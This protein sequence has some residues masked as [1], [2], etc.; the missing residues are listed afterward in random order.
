[1][2]LR[3]MQ[4]NVIKK[5]ESKRDKWHFHLKR[6]PALVTVAS[7]FQSNRREYEYRLFNNRCRELGYCSINSKVFRPA[8]N[9]GGSNEP[10]NL[11]NNANSYCNICLLSL[12]FTH[13][14]CAAQEQTKPSPKVV[15]Y[16]SKEER[17]CH[18]AS[19][20]YRLNN[21]GN[22]GLVAYQI[23]LKH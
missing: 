13:R 21:G 2:Q 4:G 22:V 14:Q 5:Q 10:T 20:K 6:L 1:M 3:L 18:H 12:S 15:R 23:P 19:S 16:R 17:S 11:Q 8:Q 7:Q 9:A